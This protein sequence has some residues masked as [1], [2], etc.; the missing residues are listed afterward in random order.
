[1]PDA[2]R[3]KLVDAFAQSSYSGNVAAVVFEADNLTERQMQLIAAEFNA[4]ETTF[5]LN[6]TTR[7]AALRFRWFTPGCEVKFCGHATIG[8]VHALIE[9][10]RFAGAFDEPG[11]II[12]IETKSG[13]ITVRVEKP[14]TAGGNATIWIDTPH[15]E[16]MATP[17]NLPP[18][19][20]HLGINMDAVDLRY[21][22]IR[23]QDE[24][25]HFAVK[26]L[27]V[28][29]E[30]KPDMG[31]V[32][33]YCKRAGDLRGVFVTCLQTLSASTV[34]QSRFFAPN[35]GVDEDPVTGSAHGPLG[36]N[37]VNCG[38]ISMIDGRA[39]FHCAQG[40]AGGRAGLVRVIVTDAG[41]GKKHVRV[42]G[43]CI[44]TASG[45]LDRLPVDVGG[46][47]TFRGC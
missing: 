33:E 43:S 26:S 19:L 45:T 4:S 9:E 37:L 41:E 46:G 16:P 36:L 23:T 10:G 15:S 44:T 3:F 11:T 24:D 14:M 6:P 34:V 21:K 8:G 20:K 32:I 13:I 2:H 17:V 40:K 31:G 18:L 35:A 7:D 22:P 12:P 28:L 30:M 42:G 27:P 29:F 25:I 47:Q 5:V 1:M 38:I 39:D